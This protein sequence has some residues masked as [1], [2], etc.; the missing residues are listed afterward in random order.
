MLL[1]SRLEYHD[2]FPLDFEV[3]QP[4]PEDAAGLRLSSKVLKTSTTVETAVVIQVLRCSSRY[5]FSNAALQRQHS[6]A[7]LSSCKREGRPPQKSS[8]TTC[9]ANANAVFG[10]CRPCCGPFHST[11]CPHAFPTL[12]YSALKIQSLRPCPLLTSL[13]QV[14]VGFA[15]NGSL[16]L[17]GES[18]F[19]SFGVLGFRKVWFEFCRI[20]TS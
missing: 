15:Q 13:K 19:L 6:G 2:I 20:L 8:R 14:N 16:K 5:V 7:P 1:S 11:R 17:M 10:I 9:K 18:F 3:D 4:H 12:L